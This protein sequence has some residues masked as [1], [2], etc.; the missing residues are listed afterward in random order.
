[1]QKTHLNRKPQDVE[2]TSR[3]TRP[4]A[5]YRCAMKVGKTTP[6][7]T[8]PLARKAL[9]ELQTRRCLTWLGVLGLV[10]LE[11]QPASCTSSNM[12]LPLGGD[13]GAD[14]IHQ[15]TMW[16]QPRRRH[17]V[18]NV[19][20]GFSKAEAHF[21]VWRPILNT[22]ERMKDEGCQLQGSSSTHLFPSGSGQ[23]HP[24]VRAVTVKVG[25]E[26]LQC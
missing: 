17:R 26:L 15:G 11:A 10:W 22:A 20:P 18:L 14:T 7:M 13:Q 16:E 9:M 19:L 6:W 4:D 3:R 2:T 23:S 8:S 24:S 25:T 21:T 1:M 12:G 5:S